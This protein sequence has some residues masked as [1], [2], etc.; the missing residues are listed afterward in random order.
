MKV[1]MR[2]ASFGDIY[3]ATSKPFTSPA[4][5]Q[6]RRAGSNLVMR[7]MPDWPASAFFHA[8]STVLPIGQ[9][10]PRPVTAT[11]RRVI[12]SRRPAQRAG[13]FASPSQV[14]LGMVL[15]VVDRLLDGGDLLR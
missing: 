8:S 10:M 6:A 1:S 4:I 9:M 13:T 5:W 3:G 15:D 7:V 12:Y 14:L 11:L 2:R